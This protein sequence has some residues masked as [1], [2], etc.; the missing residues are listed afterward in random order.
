MH[1]FFALSIYLLRLRVF[2]ECFPDQAGI[3]RFSLILDRDVWQFVNK[4]PES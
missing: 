1:E 4:L 2:H 3:G